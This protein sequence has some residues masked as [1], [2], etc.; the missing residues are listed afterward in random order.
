MVVKAV[1]S[2][3][4]KLNY[5]CSWEY[6]TILESHHNIKEIVKSVLDERE[7]SIKK[8]QNSKKGKYQSYTV[9]TLVHSDDDR[10]VVFEELKNMNL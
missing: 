6:K 9:S 4:L 1:N 5:P 8:S 10:K 2:K 3:D 7:Y